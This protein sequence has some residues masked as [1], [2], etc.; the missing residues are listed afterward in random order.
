[1]R[2]DAGGSLRNHVGAAMA[3]DLLLLRRM[4]R[5]HRIDSRLGYHVCLKPRDKGVIATTPEAR[6]ILARAILE[7][8]GDAG[9]LAFGLADNHVHLLLACSRARAGR[10]AKR[11]ALMLGWRLQI[12][13]GFERPHYEP[14]A[15]GAHLKNAF[16]YVLRQPLRHGLD[17]SID[18]WFET[19][20]LPDLLGLRV[21]LAPIVDNVRTWLP[22][23]RAKDALEM[24]DLDA[25]IVEELNRIEPAQERPEVEGSEWLDVAL[26]AAA[27]PA[28]EG[29]D[30]Q[31]MS[32]RRAIIEAVGSSLRPRELSQLVGLGESTVR[33][34]R[35]APVDERLLHAM[36][37]QLAFRQG[38][39]AL[40]CVG[41]QTESL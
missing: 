22:R 8:C 14:I 41:A 40:E 6:R 33:R 15:D 1:M 32:V 19:T 35:K 26:A 3:R 2:L 13:D 9:L 10:A 30:R 23:L 31:T 20:S 25:Q 34:L 36:R 18:P 21:P 17:P 37:R 27:L 16:R 4:M 12:F 38:C 5:R 11:L 7:S 39:R 28:L 24:V 29:L